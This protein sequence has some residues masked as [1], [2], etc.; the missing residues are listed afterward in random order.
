LQ[1]ARD[2]ED[3]GHPGDVI[4]G[5]GAGGD[6]VVVGAEEDRRP[7]C[8]SWQPGQNIRDVATGRPD[9]ATA[10]CFLGL[11]LVAQL[12]QL[13]DDDLPHLGV[14]DRADGMR[15]TSSEQAFGKDQRPGRRELS[16]R[17]GRGLR[18]RRLGGGEDK[19]EQ[20]AHQDQADAEPE[21]MNTGL[22]WFH[23]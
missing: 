21:R 5:A 1:D 2:L 15:H 6:R 4:G 9:D 18:S 7:R 13:T 12:G 19:T 8:L 3:R 10:E 14:R 22:H 17:G 16:R 20:E 11:D 23:R